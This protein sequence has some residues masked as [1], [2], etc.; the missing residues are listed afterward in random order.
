MWKKINI[1][2]LSGAMIAL[3]LLMG[4]QAITSKDGSSVKDSS[5]KQD[6]ALIR[7]GVSPELLEEAVKQREK[8]NEEIQKLKKDKS[9]S[10]T[11]KRVLAE[12]E[13]AEEQ[14]DQELYLAKVQEYRKILNDEPIKRAAES[15]ELEA[16]VLFSQLRLKEA[17]QAIEEAV[18]LDDRNPEYL[19]T[20][21]EYLRWNG[22]YQEMEEVS[23]QAVSVI[24]SAEPTDEELLS[25]AHSSL[26]LAYLYEGKYNLAHNFL[27]QS[28]EMSKKLLGEEHPDVALS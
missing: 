16:R 8:A 22:D 28:L 3:F 11:A 15:W 4:C 5:Q 17:Q 9:L 12:A 18:K 26:G 19:L 1:S 2:A 13:E 14:G 24:E 10:A 20:L 6:W 23:L 7:T 21:A 25:S 27:Q